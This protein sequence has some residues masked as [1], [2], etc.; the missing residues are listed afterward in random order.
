MPRSGPALARSPPASRAATTAAVH[1]TNHDSPTRPLPEQ[2]LWFRDRS[3]VYAHFAALSPADVRMRFGTAMGADQV[4]RYL[5]HAQADGAVAFGVFE[6]D[7]RL[8]AFAHFGASDHV[9]EL[10]LSV[11]PEFRRRGYATLLLDRARV[12]ARAHAFGALVMH[13]VADN[14]AIRELARRS[15]MTIETVDGE[16]DSRIRLRDGTPADYLREMILQQA[17]FVQRLLRWPRA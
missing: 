15:G 13:S 4:A 8:A 16:T 9:L 6:P 10:G 3:A 2:I 14:H 1:A 11:L 12:Y 5:E 17:G 7:G